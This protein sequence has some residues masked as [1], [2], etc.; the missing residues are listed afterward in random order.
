MMEILECYSFLIAIAKFVLILLFIISAFVIYHDTLDDSVFSTHRDLIIMQ[1]SWIDFKLAEKNK[2][3]GK[4]DMNF[5]RG[6]VKAVS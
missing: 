1:S 2:D 3:V 5:E 4:N 6:A